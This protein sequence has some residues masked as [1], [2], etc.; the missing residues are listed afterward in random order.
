MDV[1]IDC[2]SLS[3][4]LTGIGSYTFN[5]LDA[6]SH[7]PGIG[8]VRCFDGAGLV[9]PDFFLQQRL[10]SASSSSALIASSFES[11]KRIMR[12][13]HFAYDVRNRLRDRRFRM[14]AKELGDYVYHQPAFIMAPF[15]GRS[16]TTVHDL[17][18]IR[19]PEAHPAGRAAFLS[20]H[21]PE[22][23][24]RASRIITPSAV[25]RE[26]LLSL[27]ALSPGKVVVTPLGV[28]GCFHPRTSEECRSALAERDLEYRGYLLFV[29]T[30]EPRKNLA[31]LLDAWTSLPDKV[32]RRYP[33]VIV[34]G[35]G[36]GD[37][38]L[39]GRIKMLERHMP[40]RYLDYVPA[41]ALAVLYSAAAM[42]VYPSAYEGFG[43][44]VLESMASATPVVCCSNTAMEEYAG[45]AAFLSVAGDVDALRST[46]LMVLD[47]VERVSM[48]VR[49]GLE[50][51]SRHTWSSC[52]EMTL[53]VYQSVD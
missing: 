36:W 12:N 35:R 1:L 5:L 27:F 53:R 11:L 45:D 13:H 24:E 26:E 47:D 9:S 6:L 40:L 46:I 43:L 18:F 22:T 8:D 23:L 17:S 7:T 25:T 19:F 10:S 32:R 52:A 33:L 16:V 31:H 49:R 28:A 37:D 48:H 4:P 3:A 50:V 42:V 2:E 41:G 30:L 38:P 51:A 21:L 29:G 39:L 20:R 34:G 15:P 44:P 14:A